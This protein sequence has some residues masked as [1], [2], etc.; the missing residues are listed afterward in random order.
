MVA[1]YVPIGLMGG[2]ASAV[3]S[4]E[5]DSHIVNS[6]NTHTHSGLTFGPASA[7]RLLIVTL[8]YNANNITSLSN[9]TIGGVSASRLVRHLYN[10]SG[11]ATLTPSSEI[12]AAAVPNGTS[13]SVV[14]S[15]NTSGNLWNSSVSVYAA[16]NLISTTPTATSASDD[17]SHPGTLNMS[18]GVQG[19]GF[20]I[21]AMF[22][23]GGGTQSSA[24]ISGMTQAFFDGMGSGNGAQTGGTASSP[25]STTVS[26]TTTFSGGG[27][28]EIT[29]TMAS[30]R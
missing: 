17:V 22:F 18:I 9:V 23:C 24:S 26:T 27:V 2:A 6:G 21:A 11:G 29:G 5:D 1:F 14:L 12:W 15:V 8:T 19:G 7:D 13:G 20:A 10:Q 16:T 30:F 4:F 25:V 3:C 28:Q